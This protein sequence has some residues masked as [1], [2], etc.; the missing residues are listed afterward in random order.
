[1]PKSS[2]K[3]EKFNERQCLTLLGFVVG[4]NEIDEKLRKRSSC[5]LQAADDCTR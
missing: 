1:V 5:Q 4:F 2:L 3:R